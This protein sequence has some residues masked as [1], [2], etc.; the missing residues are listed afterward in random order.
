VSHVVYVLMFGKTSIILLH[1][2]YYF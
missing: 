2:Y 1:M